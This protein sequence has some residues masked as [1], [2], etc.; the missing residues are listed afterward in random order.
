MRYLVILS[1]S[2]CGDERNYNGLKLAGA[3]ACNGNTEVRTFLMGD[4]ATA[5]TSGD[6]MTLQGYFDLSETLEIVRERGG[7]IGVCSSGME[8]RGINSD[9][10]VKGAHRS[11]LSE[12]TEW[13]EWADKV[14]TF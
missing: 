8:A 11:S 12:L 6:D 14:L 9:H 13:S 4:A 2:P 10:L 5:A 3:L 1:N 7:A